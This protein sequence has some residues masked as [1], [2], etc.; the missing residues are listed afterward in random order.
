[1]V[2]AVFARGYS[3]IRFGPGVVNAV[4]PARRAWAEDGLVIQR[5]GAGNMNKTRIRIGSLAAVVLAT[6]LAACTTPH[7]PNGSSAQVTPAVTP[8]EAYSHDIHFY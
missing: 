8:V 2:T 7:A 5:E 4:T 6:L 1:M 3:C